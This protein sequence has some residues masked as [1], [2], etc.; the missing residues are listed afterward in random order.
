MCE[1]EYEI[2]NSDY[3]PADNI[4][5]TIVE[6]PVDT[7]NL[8]L[9]TNDTTKVGTYHIKVRG[10]V[11]NTGASQDSQVFLVEVISCEDAWIDISQAEYEMTYYLGDADE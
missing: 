2:F 8:V 3:S 10:T 11:T 1:V 7:F 4:L 5:F 6:D 9:E